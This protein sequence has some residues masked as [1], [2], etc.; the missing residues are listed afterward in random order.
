MLASLKSAVVAVISFLVMSVR[1]AAIKWAPLS[2][3]DPGRAETSNKLTVRGKV[4]S[5]YH[6]G[7][8]RRR[9]SLKSYLIWMPELK[10]TSQTKHL[11]SDKHRIDF[12]SAYWNHLIPIP[13]SLHISRY[14]DKE[15]AR[16]F[17]LR[18]LIFFIAFPKER[19]LWPY[20]SV[21]VHQGRENTQ[22]FRDYWNLS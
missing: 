6:S 7:L 13:L 22:P 8:T 10:Q 12:R 1:D 19:D 17:P 4:D 11:R 15:E 3:W 5:G 20:T 21:T 14:V 9:S 16:Y 2:E 18:Q